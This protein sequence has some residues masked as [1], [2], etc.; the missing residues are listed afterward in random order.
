MKT[1]LIVDD[2]NCV[3]ELMELLVGSLEFKVIGEAENGK[4]AVEKYKELKPDLV[5][6]DIMMSEMN[7]IEALRQ[8]MEFDS[9]AKV[10][11][12]SSL[13][14]Q[15]FIAEEAAALGAKGFLVKPVELKNVKEVVNKVLNEGV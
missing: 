1:V 10:I 11:I 12:T 4:V 9:E 2:C 5:F 13:A 3:R 7:G 8:I 6:M 14:D 15:R